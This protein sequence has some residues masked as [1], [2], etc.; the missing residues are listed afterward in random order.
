MVSFINT[1]IIVIAR[2]VFPVCGN[3]KYMEREKGIASVP[4]GKRYKILDL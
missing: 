1:E 3:I 2:K 4:I